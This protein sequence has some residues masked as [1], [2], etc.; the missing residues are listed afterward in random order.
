MNDGMIKIADFG[1]ARV[2]HEMELS[3]SRVGT[4]M[5]RAPEIN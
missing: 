3:N 2:L 4:P 1:F 5:T